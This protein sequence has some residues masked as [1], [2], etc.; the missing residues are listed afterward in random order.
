[1]AYVGDQ[2]WHGLGQ[3]L[4]E[5]ASIDVW[6]KASGMDMPLEEGEVSTTVDDTQLILPGKKLIY[7]AD[8]MEALSVVGSK[9]K[10]VQPIEMLEF[11]K[12]Y[13]GENAILET[14]GMLF[15]GRV[16]WAMARLEGELNIAGDITKPYLLLN[17]SCDGS[18][19]TSAR[20]TTVRVVC[21]N[22]LS[23]ASA[24]DKPTVTIRHNQT[25]C[26]DA[27]ATEM[28]E[29]YASLKAH[30]KTMKMLAKAKITAAQSERFVKLMLDNCVEA[31]LKDAKV[32]RAGTRVL[33]LYNGEGRGAGEK[34]TK[35][36]AYGL[37][38]AVTEYYDHEYGRSQDSR[39]N[40]A[41]FGYTAKR[42]T[43]FARDLELAVAA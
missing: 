32:S 4:E 5:G 10:T 27:L 41:F 43:Q 3:E 29:H 37:L 20:L 31:N 21:N 7:R 25:F 26:K 13:V 35:N 39:L 24:S 1:M 38:Q 33:E 19:S 23:Y 12:R 6:A 2:P 34:S 16:Y 17:S 14:A 28:E 11:F 42:K 30:G 18:T 15:G 36:T 8:T 40:E 22:T 9:Y